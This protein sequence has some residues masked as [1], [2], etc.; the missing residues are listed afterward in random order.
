MPIKQNG[1]GGARLIPKRN[2]WPYVYSIHKIQKI[3]PSG[4]GL[5]LYQA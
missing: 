3:P 1:A 4:G 5:S 2:S